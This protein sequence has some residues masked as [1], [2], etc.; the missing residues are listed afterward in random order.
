MVFWQSL[1]KSLFFQVAFGLTPMVVLIFIS[2][3][4]LG[5][6][7]D[8]FSYSTAIFLKIFLKRCS[9]SYVLRELQI[10]QQ[11]TSARVLEW[12]KSKTLKTP[13]ADKNVEQQELSHCSW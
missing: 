6:V 12:P 5:T 2:S 8:I 4:V 13:N 11:D 10:K 9:T 7:H 1:V 3:L